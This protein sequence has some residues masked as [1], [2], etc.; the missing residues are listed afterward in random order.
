MGA[1]DLAKQ[2]N[3]AYK[4]GKATVPPLAIASAS[5]FAFLAYQCEALSPDVDGWLAGL[6]GMTDLCLV[7]RNMKGHLPISCFALYSAAAIVAPSIVPYTLT[8]MWPTILAIAA[9]AEGKTDAPSEAETK[10]LIKKWSGQNMHRAYM[11]GTAT[12]M[13]AVAMLA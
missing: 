6:A 3:R 9:K 10:A 7:A 1:E 12:L 8:V 5:C 13:G 11:V 4:L 2:W